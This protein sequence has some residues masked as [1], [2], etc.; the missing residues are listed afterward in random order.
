MFQDEQNI[1]ISNGKQNWLR[2]IG[3]HD[4]YVTIATEINLE[5]D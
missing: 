3:T 5:V 1:E 2:E 4:F